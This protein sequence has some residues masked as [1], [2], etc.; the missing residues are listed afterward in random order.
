MSVR[1]VVTVMRRRWY[2]LAMA[3]LCTAVAVLVV[4][5]RPLSYEACAELFVMAPRTSLNPNV[6]TNEAGSLDS[7]TG[8][9]TRALMSPAMQAKIRSEGY[10]EYD[11]EMT[12]TGSNENPLYGEPSLQICSTSRDSDLAMRTAKV[13]TQEYQLIMEQRQAQQKVNH[14]LMMTVSVVAA[15]VALPIRGHPSQAYLGVG[16]FG[17]I[18]GMAV[19]LW[20]DPFL[21]GRR[22]HSQRASRSRQLS[23]NDAPSRQY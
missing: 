23:A 16:L 22:R 20:S 13:A 17:V 2:V 18:A 19:T 1:A 6:Y 14:K 9:V 3:L 15:P 7:M 4:H 10:A 8:L 11:A 12:N 21:V 5:K